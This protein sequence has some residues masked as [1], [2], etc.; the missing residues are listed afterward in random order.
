MYVLQ[1]SCATTSLGDQ[2]LNVG[3]CEPKRDEK[4]PNGRGIIFFRWRFVYFFFC[5]AWDIGFVYVLP[6]VVPNPYNTS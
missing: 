6:V 3:S 5:V 4:K 2:A 1:R